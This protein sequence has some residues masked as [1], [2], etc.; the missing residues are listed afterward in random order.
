[1]FYDDLDRNDP[2]IFGES[3]KQVIVNLSTPRFHRA[4]ARLRASLEGYGIP[5]LD[6][7]SEAQ[8]KAPLHRDNPYAFKVYAIEQARRAGADH[9]L[10][11]DSS[12]YAIAD[13]AP[14]FDIIANKG[15]FME[16]A[17]H[18]AGK[19]ANDNCLQH[20][21]ITRDEAMEIPMFSAGFTGINFNDMFAAEF[22]RQ[23]KEAM[24]AG[25]FKGGWTNTNKTESQDARCEGHR[26]DMVCASIIAHKLGMTYEPGGTY[27]QYAA[28]SD[29]VRAE[30]IIFKLQG[31]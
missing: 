21:G 18:V 15:Y 14:I 10:W 4:Q 13:P 7:N 19:W 27:F 24:L 25:A 22:F 31:I 28:P 11:L 9:V 23:W 17:G 6:Y 5:Y 8:V 2:D 3:M 30:S 29:P 12:C 16:E 26:H 20:F 1:M